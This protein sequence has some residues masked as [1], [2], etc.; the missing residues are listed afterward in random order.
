MAVMGCIVNGPGRIQARQHRHLAA[1]HLRGTQ[2][3]GLRRRPADD[4]AERRPHRRRIHRHPGRLRRP[5][6][7][8]EL[9]AWSRPPGRPTAVSL[10]PRTGQRA[11]I[12]RNLLPF[13]H[14]CAQTF[15]RFD[16]F[17]IIETNRLVR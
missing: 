4:D 14:L 16:P 17:A 1:R 12:I 3:A 7:R 5:E 11:R 8:G 2:G 13:S 15:G 9:I 6:V 10:R